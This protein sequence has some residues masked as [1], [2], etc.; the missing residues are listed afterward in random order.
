MQLEELRMNKKMGEDDP[1]L[2]TGLPSAKTASAGQ[3]DEMLNELRAAWNEWDALIDRTAAGEAVSETDR[4]AA[5][6][7]MVDI[8]NRRTYL[9]NLLREVDEVLES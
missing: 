9:R 4:T 2:E 1:T 6:D 3:A 8:L 5:R 7:K